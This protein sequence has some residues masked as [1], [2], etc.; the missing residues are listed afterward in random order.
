MNQNLYPNSFDTHR[1]ENSLFCT[2]KC[3]SVPNLQRSLTCLVIEVVIICISIVDK[4]SEHRIDSVRDS[5]A[6]YL[7]LLQNQN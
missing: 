5:F 7:K 6:Q 2:Q 4:E 3:T 1:K